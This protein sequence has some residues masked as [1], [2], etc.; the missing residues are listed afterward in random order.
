[1]K[2]KQVENWRLSEDWCT[3]KKVINRWIKQMF[4]GGGFEIKSVK[5]NFTSA[6][7]LFT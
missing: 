6:L 7:F 3:K 1:M 4:E 5:A 2:P